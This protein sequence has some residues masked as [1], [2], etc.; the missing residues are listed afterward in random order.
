MPRGKPCPPGATRIIK[1]RVWVR[2]P[3]HPNALKGWVQRSRLV[4][5]ERLGRPLRSDE[6][7]HHIDQDMLNDEP[8]NLQVMSHGE[9]SRL[10]NNS[11]ERRE[12]FRSLHLGKTVSPETREKIRAGLLGKPLSEERRR[13]ISDAHRGR[14]HSPEHRAKISAGLL[15]R[16]AEHRAAQGTPDTPR[17][18]TRRQGRREAA[19]RYREKQHMEHDWD[20]ADAVDWMEAGR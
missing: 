12:H 19:R 6:H 11:P 10:H 13:K 7:V 8:S 2:L 17:D 4:A 14:K 9:H 3:D 1:G 20:R 18:E 15:K 16:H 5:S